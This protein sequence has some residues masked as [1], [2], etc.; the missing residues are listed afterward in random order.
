MQAKKLFTVALA[1]ACVM[2]F[3][4]IFEADSSDAAE[5]TVKVVP[6]QDPTW[7]GFTDM[8]DGHFT[9]Y[10]K[11][12]MTENVTVKVIVFD[13]ESNAEKDRTEVTLE[14]SVETSV[15]TGFG[16][17]SDGSKMVYYKVVD[18]ED[19]EIFTDGSYE[20]SV[21][22]SLWKNTS[23]YVAVVIIVIVIV[24]VV[25]VIMRNRTKK[26]VGGGKSFTE[27]EAERKAKRTN[28]VAEKQTYQAGEKKTRK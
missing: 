6:Y 1:L 5:S 14:P 12:E 28:K 11:S 8:K 20:I 18:V 23:T 27:L 13:T 16:Y 7:G 4:F 21:S 26:V 17:G 19:K 3:A 9:V 25:V 22:H 10:L 24:I 2:S 15:R